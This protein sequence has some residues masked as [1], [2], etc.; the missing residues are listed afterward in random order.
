MNAGEAAWQAGA[1]AA[2]VLAP[3]SGLIAR[4]DPADFGES[5]F[6][7]LARAAARPAEVA[8]AGLQFGAAL[9]RIWPVAGARWLGGKADARH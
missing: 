9:A 4:L 2:D 7:V 3:E 8:A 1:E 5:V 6:S